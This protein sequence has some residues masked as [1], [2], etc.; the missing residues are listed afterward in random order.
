M[1]PADGNLQTLLIVI[2]TA[3]CGLQLWLSWRGVSLF[4][5]VCRW[6]RVWRIRRNLGVS[7]R[8]AYFKATRF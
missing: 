7:W 1:S 5:L 8:A 3:I 6:Q 2:L 4:M